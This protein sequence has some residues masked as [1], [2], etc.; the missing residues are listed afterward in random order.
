MVKRRQ[1]YGWKSL[2]LILSVSPFKNFKRVRYFQD[3][4]NGKVQII[5]SKMYLTLWT[6][7]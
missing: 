5:H 4:S 6:D 2:Y 7:R 1:S 3:A